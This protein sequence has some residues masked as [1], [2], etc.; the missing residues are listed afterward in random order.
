MLVCCV[1]RY[2]VIVSRQYTKLLENWLESLPAGQT[3]LP[4]HAW[5]VLRGL[6]G[7]LIVGG[8]VFSIF[9]G[10]IALC[11]ATTLAALM[12]IDTRYSLCLV[13]PHT[14][15]QLALRY[16]GHLLTPAEGTPRATIGQKCNKC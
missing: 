12:A 3:A 14:L 15:T 11:F 6:S 1:C 13:A 5:A 8:A 10:A 9:F 4:S 7:F 2:A 16:A